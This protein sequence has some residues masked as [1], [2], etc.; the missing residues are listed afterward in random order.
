M[1]AQ[2]FGPVATSGAT[3]DL[4][5]TFYA[6][7]AGAL[8]GQVIHIENNFDNV[9]TQDITVGGAAY[10]YASSQ[11]NTPQPIAFGNVREND[12]LADQAVSIT[13]NVVADGY[14]ED[15]TVFS[16]GT[17]GGVQQTGMPPVAIIGAGITDTSLT[18]NIDTTTAG[19]KS[20]QAG[21][22]MFS[23]GTTTSGLGITHL[24][25]QSVDVT[26]KVFRL[27]QASAAAPNPVVL[28]DAHVGDTRTQALTITNT[29]AAD[30]FSGKVEC[31]HCCNRGTGHRVWNNQ[32]A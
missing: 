4:S 15:L 13:N 6:Q 8:T 18:V 7:D 2:N 30:G 26:G 27:A 25:D 19:D 17:T 32:S 24:G 9:A 3:S 23:D 22:A 29:A 21:Y 20:G 16:N 10:R 12:I 1:T 11:I 5:V 28:A 31:H 14:S